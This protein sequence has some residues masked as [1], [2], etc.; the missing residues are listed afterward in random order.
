VIV[1]R[2]NNPSSSSN[3]QFSQMTKEQQQ[4]YIPPQF[5]GKFALVNFIYQAYTHLSPSYRGKLHFH[6][7]MATSCEN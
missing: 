3:M 2:D 4:D 6:T 5:F 1:D 7:Y